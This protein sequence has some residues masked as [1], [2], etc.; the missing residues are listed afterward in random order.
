M[1]YKTVRAL[2]RRYDSPLLHERADGEPEA[3]G[4]G[5]VVLVDDGAARSAVSA[6]GAAGVRRRPLVRR[7]ARH[8][9]RRHRDEHVGEH[10]VEPDLQRQRV[11]EGKELE[12]VEQQFYLFLAPA[13]IRVLNCVIVNE[14]LLLIS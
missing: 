3:V 6:V 13:V 9:P 1:P 4:D 14:G 2:V 12:K 10:D 7:E 8:D 11:H 5:E